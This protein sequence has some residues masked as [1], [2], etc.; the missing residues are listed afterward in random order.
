M[1]FL[2]SRVK[3]SALTCFFRFTLSVLFLL[4]QNHCKNFVNGKNL[5]NGIAIG[6]GIH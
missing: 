2:G 3:L 4:L 6:R 1:P 5:R